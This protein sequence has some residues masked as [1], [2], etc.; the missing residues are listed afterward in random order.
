M[1][2]LFGDM[3]RYSIGLSGCKEFVKRNVK[4]SD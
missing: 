3:M 4:V 2:G 1:R